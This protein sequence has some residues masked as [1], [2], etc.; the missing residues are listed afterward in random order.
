[1]ARDGLGLIDDAAES[2]ALAA[3]LDA[4]AASVRPGA[5]GSARRT[6]DAEARGIDLRPHARN[7]RAHLVRAALEATA[8]QAADVLDA[9]PAARRCCAPTAA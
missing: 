4:T 6:G 2:E 5:R 3:S 7:D 1:M 8:Y 9:M